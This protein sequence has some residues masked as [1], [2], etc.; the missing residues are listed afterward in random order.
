[1]A[2]LKRH[3]SQ[4]AWL[5]LIVVLLLAI[6]SLAEQPNFSTVSIHTTYKVAIVV[7]VVVAIIA[8][9]RG[10][11]WA[12][13]LAGSVLLTQAIVNAVWFLSGN[14]V[15]EG[16]GTVAVAAVIAI[17]AAGAVLLDPTGGDSTSETQAIGGP[18]GVGNGFPMDIGNTSGPNNSF[19]RTRV[20]GG[21][22]PGPLNSN[23]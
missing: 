20:R 10:K 2:D 5:L 16:A 6:R 21:R 12:P 18:E 14:Y 4:A 22:G 15:K 1:M 11:R 23:R 3:L 19:Q 9:R 7:A 13:Y 8:Q 17:L